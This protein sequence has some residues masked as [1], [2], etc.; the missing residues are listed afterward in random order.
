M[1]RLAFTV[2]YSR[3]K[4][5]YRFRSELIQLSDCFKIQL[6]DALNRMEQSQFVEAGNIGPTQVAYI[7]GIF[8]GK[9]YQAFYHLCRTIDIHATPCRFTFGLE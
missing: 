9:V 6:V 1:Q 3:L 2:F 4:I 5:L 7:H 8:A